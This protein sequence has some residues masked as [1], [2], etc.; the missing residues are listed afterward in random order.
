MV[1]KMKGLSR[2]WTLAVVLSERAKK[3]YQ[4]DNM[5]ANASCKNG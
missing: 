3:K 1:E 5:T 2:S 4:I